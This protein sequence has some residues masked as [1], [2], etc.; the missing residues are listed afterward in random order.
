[1]PSTPPKKENLL[2]NLVCNI[3]V[4]TFA[5]M[6]LSTDD[7]LG[8]LWGGLVALAFPLSYGL[9]DF[10]RRRK[11]NFISLIGIASI[12]LSGGLLLGKAGGFWFA[13]KDGVLPLVIGAAMLATLRTKNP[14]VREL[15]YNDQIIDVGRVD[16]VLAE[17]G[18]QPAL[19]RLLTRTSLWLGGSFVVSAGLNFC[20]ARYLINSPPGT[21]AFN[22]ELGRMHVLSWPVIVLP[23]MVVMMFVFWRLVAGLRQLTGLTTD[24]IF[25]APEPKA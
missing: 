10:V 17:R 23:S 21:P 18:Q 4:P 11:A 12:M 2:I 25:R 22:A 20:L 7:R 3:A 1:M 5:F 14:L 8:P 16:A 6:K 24:E 15:L 13:V 9:Y 19:T